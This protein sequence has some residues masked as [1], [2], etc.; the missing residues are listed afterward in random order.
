MYANVQQFC[1]LPGSRLASASVRG[2]V[3]RIFNVV[4]G[5]RLIEFR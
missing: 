2:T 5:T 4:D 3:I 1:V